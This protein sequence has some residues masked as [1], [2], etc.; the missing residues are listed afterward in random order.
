MSRRTVKAPP[1]GDQ[2][3]RDRIRAAGLRVTP[4]RLAVL[5]V[6]R[7]ANGAHMSAEDV[8]LRLRR[9]GAAMDRSTV[10]RVLADLTEAALLE[11]VRLGDGV[12][13]FEIQEVAHHHA[14]CTRCGATTDV[15]IEAVRALAT[16]LHRD[17]GF[18]LG[19][20]PLLLPG[21]CAACAAQ[22]ATRAPHAA[23]A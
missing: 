5:T 17:T 20:H 18:A 7:S 15:S 12:A 10:Y 16:R 19:H 2:G 23:G 8:W 4:Q 14:V 1:S 13:R 22:L 21:L 11:Q 6:L 9:A 3:A